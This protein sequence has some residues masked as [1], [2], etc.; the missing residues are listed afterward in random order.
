MFS[1]HLYA[2]KMKKVIKV[3]TLTDSK[4]GYFLAVNILVIPEVGY[5]ILNIFVNK[6]PLQ[7]LCNVQVT[8]VWIGSPRK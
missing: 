3:K 1:V 7:F 4:Y 2:T 5:N 8:I 6:V